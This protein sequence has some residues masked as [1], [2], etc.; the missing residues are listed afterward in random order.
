MN[1]EVMGVGRSEAKKR[2]DLKSRKKIYD[3]ITLVDRKENRLRELLGIASSQTNLSK[4]EYMINA[5]YTQLSRDGIT[6]DMLPTDGK[7]TAPAKINEA[8]QYE[9][10]LVTEW[11]LEDDF[12]YQTYF[13]HPEWFFEYYVSVFQTVKAAKDYI[14]NKFKRKAH[15]EQWGYTIYGRSFEANTKR[16]AYD[17]YREM[18]KEAIAE[19]DEMLA[20]ADD[21]DEVKDFLQILNEKQEPDL[22]EPVTYDDVKGD[23]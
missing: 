2:A 10:Y 9:I 19:A 18:V 1:D 22:V 8:K 5:V 13:D 3:Q 16:D 6:I 20:V 14:R 23:E 4:N 17:A 15:P 21:G 7:Y 12:T 11:M